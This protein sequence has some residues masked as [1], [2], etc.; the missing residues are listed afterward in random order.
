[1]DNYGISAAGCVILNEK[2]EVLL[3]RQTYDGC[4]WSL[5]GGRIDTGEA[6]WEAAARESSEEIGLTVDQLQ[7]SGMYYLPHRHAYYYVFIAGSWSGIP[8]PD[9]DEIDRYGFFALD[10]LPGPITNFNIERIQDALEYTGH[11]RLRD[12]NNTRRQLINGKL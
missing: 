2:R 12:Q 11:A 9:G 8:V 5:P 3:L 10:K 6:A 7:L 1:M 4:K